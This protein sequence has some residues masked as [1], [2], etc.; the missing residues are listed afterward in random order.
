M[1]NSSDPFGLTADTISTAA[2]E[3]LGDACQIVDCDEVSIVTEPDGLAQA[4]ILMGVQLTGR[5]F[6]AG[7]TIYLPHAVNAESP[8]DIAQLAHE[9]T[10]VWQYDLLQAGYGPINGALGYWTMGAIDQARF[11]SGRG[12][13]YKGGGYIETL[14]QKVQSCFLGASCVGSLFTPRGSP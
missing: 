9:L 4:A 3:N 5:A 2:R 11:S 10:H 1:C 13:P 7:H 14:A 6:T 8:D 12:D